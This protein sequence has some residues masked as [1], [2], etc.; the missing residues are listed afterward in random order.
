MESV[1]LL[2]IKISQVW[3]KKKKKEKKMGQVIWNLA[4]C[5]DSRKYFLSEGKLALLSSFDSRN[6]D[7]HTLRSWKLH[8]SFKL[9]W[10]QQM[11]TPTTWKNTVFIPDLHSRKSPSFIQ[12]QGRKL[13]D[14]A[15]PLISCR[16][17]LFLTV[18][19]S[20][21]LSTTAK[22]SALHWI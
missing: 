19:L 11:D 22:V 4:Q 20:Y 12:T 9:R 18:T 15:R 21:L 2:D 13:K 14:K 16:H 6:Y 1:F 5:C 3:G 10:I 8:S 17:F 7:I